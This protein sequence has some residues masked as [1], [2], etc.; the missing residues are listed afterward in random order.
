[1]KRYYLALFFF[2]GYIGNGINLYAQ[3]VAGKETVIFLVRHAEK[4]LTE[5]S[6]DPSLSLEGKKHAEQ[7]AAILKDA[8]I[9][10]IYSTATKRTEQTALPLLQKLGLSIIHYDAK[11]SDLAINLAKKGKDK[12]ILVVSHSNVVPKLLNEWTKS[13]KYTE[14][15]DY[16]DLYIV[17]ISDS[18]PANVIKLYF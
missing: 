12:R 15:E 2:L 18:Q 5:S 17:K 11:D 9:E 16:G 13:K 10:A 8:G 6:S 7:L 3:Q 14:S 1:M 4:D